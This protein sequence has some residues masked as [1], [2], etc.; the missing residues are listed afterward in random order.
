MDAVKADGALRKGAARAAN[1]RSAL[2]AANE[3]SALGAVNERCVLGRQCRALRFIE[4]G[5]SVRIE[6]FWAANEWRV[7]LKV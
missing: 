6:L 2:R 5:V 3:R 1:E 7:L 4:D